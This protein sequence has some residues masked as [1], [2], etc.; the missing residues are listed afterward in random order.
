MEGPLV[1]L[2]R[3]THLLYTGRHEFNEIKT[4]IHWTFSLIVSVR[5]GE[6]PHCTVCDLFLNRA[7]SLE[8]AYET[9][10]SGLLAPVGSG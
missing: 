4:L 9:D 1:F 2:S 10:K 7:F 3:L 6:I 8:N 5:S